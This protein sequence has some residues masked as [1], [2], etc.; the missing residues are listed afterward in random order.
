MESKE[1]YIGIDYGTSN[2]CIGI[3]L[4]SKV[5]IAPNKIGERTT[6]SIV[7]FVD[8]EIYIGEDTLNQKIEGNNLIYEV[9]RFIGLTY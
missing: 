9:K 2:S 7:S 8:N 6:P 1:Y 5:N 4:K 3:Y